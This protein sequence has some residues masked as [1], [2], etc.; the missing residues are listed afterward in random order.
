MTGA[1]T[2]SGQGRRRWRGAVVTLLIAVALAVM[3]F[4]ANDHWAL[5]PDLLPYTL[6]W[7]LTPVS[8]FLP[9]VLALWLALEVPRRLVRRTRSTGAAAHDGRSGTEVPVTV[10][11]DVPEPEEPVRAEE[12]EGAEA[13]SG[14]EQPERLRIP[15]G[16][17]RE[18]GVEH[19]AEMARALGITWRDELIH[20]HQSW[21]IACLE[22]AQHRAAGLRR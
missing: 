20:D 17:F 5:R 4:V 6:N 14:A 3:I 18:L 19:R 16:T 8:G 10:A 22:A 12:P 1:G 11:P 13:P 15:A 2:A 21:A 7:I 9:L